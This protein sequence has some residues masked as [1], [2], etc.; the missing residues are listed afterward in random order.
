MTNRALISAIALCFAAAGCDSQKAAEPPKPKTAAV[1]PLPPEAPKAAAA[2]AN[3]DAA[4]MQVADTK[5]GAGKA[6]AA[7][8][9]GTKGCGDGRC[10]VKIKDVKP[11]KP[12]TA[13]YNAEHLEVAGAKQTITWQVTGGWTFD[14]NGIDLP[15]GTNQFSNAQGGGTN[16]FSVVDENSDDQRYK[17]TVRLTKGK[18]K[19]EMDPSIVN[20]AETIDPN[21]PPP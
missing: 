12:C 9:P 2:S 10:V 13:T 14:A 5:A 15:V 8:R 19:C 4:P 18:D 3:Q 20:G 17:Y 7:K 21:Y 11:G 16:K 6:K 1:V